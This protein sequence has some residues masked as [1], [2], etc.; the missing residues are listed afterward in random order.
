MNKKY[1]NNW[2]NSVK[3]IFAGDDT[4]DEDAMKVLK[5]YAATFRISSNKDLVTFADKIVN[6][7]EDV[8]KILKHTE[9][10]LK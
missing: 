9:A 2:K 5:G 3:V 7:T 10:C 8:V 6:S 4:T 1:G